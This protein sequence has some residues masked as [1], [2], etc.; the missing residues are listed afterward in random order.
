MTG[1]QT[2]AALFAVPSGQVVT[3]Q[4]IFWEE[5][6]GLVLRVRFIAPQIA[7]LGGTVDYETAA[8]D[9]QYLCETYVLPQIEAGADKPEQVILSLSDIEVPFGE[10]DP[11]ATQFFEAYSLQGDSCIW[12]AY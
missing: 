2:Q 3:L 4:D 6:D 9:M 11:E 5:G 7:R 1:A 10:A 12:E 8:I